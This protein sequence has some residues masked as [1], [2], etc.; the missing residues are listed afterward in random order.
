MTERPTGFE[1]APEAHPDRYDKIPGVR[2]RRPEESDDEYASSLT[3]ALSSI[4]PEYCGQYMMPIKGKKPVEEI[5]S[6]A[7]QELARTIEEGTE[8][9]EP[10]LAEAWELVKQ[11]ADRNWTEKV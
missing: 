7:R 10:T 5:L 8:P 9:K 1:G 2:P 3:E 6:F 4:S 11:H